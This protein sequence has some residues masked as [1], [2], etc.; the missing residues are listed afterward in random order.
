[1][2]IVDGE[3]DLAAIGALLSDR[4][5][6]T[7]LLTLLSGGLT[8]ASALAARADVSP[9]LASN[10]L[11]KLADGGLIVAE[12]RGRQRMYRLSG[13]SIADAL[14]ALI[15]LAPLA[16]VHSLRGSY[17]RDNI[18]RAR[19][20][21]DHLAGRAG[22]ALTGGLLAGGLLVETEDAYAVTGAGRRTFATLG[23]DVESLAGRPRPLTRSCLDWSERLPHLAGTLGA[24]LTAE[25]LRRRW[26]DSREASRIVTV[27]EVGRQ[28]LA[29]QFGVDPR[30]LDLPEERSRVA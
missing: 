1:M 12:R 18:R 30:S 17:E 15:P 14:E 10:H 23:I 6:A 27:T 19:L 9:S 20:C 7:F 2:F 25:L 26:L 8:S 22:V 16:R 4:T 11:R 24:A 21:Y 28:G 29:A 5:R 13:Q 3:A